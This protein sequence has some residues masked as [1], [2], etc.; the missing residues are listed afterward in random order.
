MLLLLPKAY[1]ECDWCIIKHFFMQINLHVVVT[2][3]VVA[4][5]K[6][7]AICDERNSLRLRLYSVVQQHNEKLYCCSRCKCTVE[8]VTGTYMTNNVSLNSTPCLS[9]VAA[10]DAAVVVVAA[11]AVDMVSKHH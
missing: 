4:V 9:T 11:V 6:G 10:A 3:I 2:V 5:S 1:A 8:V 7:I